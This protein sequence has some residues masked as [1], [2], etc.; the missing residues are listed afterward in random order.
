[1]SIP[2]LAA[3]PRFVLAA[4]FCGADQGC[5]IQPV[6]IGIEDEDAVLIE[7][8]LRRPFEGIRCRGCN[9]IPPRG[10]GPS[11]A[12]MWSVARV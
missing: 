11:Y 1:M 8:V 4:G 3:L 6:L 5:T 9:K 10:T 7:W 2:F 12:W